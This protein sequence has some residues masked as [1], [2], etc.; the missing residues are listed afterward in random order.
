MIF[1]P[2][3]VAHALPGRLRLLFNNGLRQLGTA[4]AILVK[5]PGILSVRYNPVIHSLL[6]Y[7]DEKQLSRQEVLSFIEGH[8]GLKPGLQ[9]RDN[10]FWPLLAGGALLLS[11]V[12]K[13][14]SQGTN[15]SSSFL[16]YLAAGITAY[17]VLTHRDST[18]CGDK[19]MHLDTLAG[20]VSLFSLKSD[21]RSMGLFITW[22]LNFIEVMFGWPQYPNQCRFQ[23]GKSFK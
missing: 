20:L 16:D 2:Y 1:K 9:S 21:G 12:Y 15:V 17:S 5:K 18:Q 7:Y 6:V 23:W 4:D 14:S 8:L 22:L 19:S 3:Q 10:L 11:Y 13:R